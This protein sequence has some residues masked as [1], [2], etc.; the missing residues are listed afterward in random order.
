[1]HDMPD[2]SFYQEVYEG[3]LLS[4]PRFRTLS[5]RGKEWLEKLERCCRVIPYGTDSRKM[6]ICALAETMA[7]WEQKHS[8]LEESIGAVRV[9]YQQNDAPLQRQLL[10]NVSGYMEIYRGVS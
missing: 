8:C 4:E 3:T 5:L 10:Q 2:Y 9:R 6:A 7:V 1:M